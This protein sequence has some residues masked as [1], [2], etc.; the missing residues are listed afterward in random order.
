VP[1]VSRGF[2]VILSL[3]CALPFSVLIYPSVLMY[4]GVVLAILGRN[5]FIPLAWSLVIGASVHLLY[6]GFLRERFVNPSSNADFLAIVG[7]IHQRVVISSWTHIWIRKSEE[8]F[9]ATTFNPYFNAIIVS[10]SMQN[11]ILQSPESG[12]VL[13]AFHLFVDLI[14]STIMFVIFTYG[15]VLFLIPLAASI[16][17]MQMYG[18]YFMLIIMSLTMSF[19][20]FCL[21]MFLLVLVI[22]GTF[23]RHE[24]A[25]DSVQSIYGMH[26]NVAKVQVEEGHIL[27]EEEAQAVIW[28]VRE[29]EKNKRGARRV[30]LSTILAIFSF[31]LGI[32]V[33]SRFYMPYSFLFLLIVGSPY[34]VAVAVW[35]CSYLILRR[36]D[37]NA[38]AEV[39]HKTTDYDEPLWMD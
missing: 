37:R 1:S 24:P 6:L 29:W 32:L 30:G 7:R 11:R 18:G 16:I 27:D 26:P 33:V 10:E 34:L 25:F 39:F 17:Q 8:P 15:S 22:K 31:I 38:M 4:P 12:E 14:G 35:V 19:L 13:L 28:A 21:V 3:L 20:P 2:M 36:W 23:W 9:I 5:W